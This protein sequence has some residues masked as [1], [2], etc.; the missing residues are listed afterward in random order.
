MNQ[1]GET[2]IRAIEIFKEEN[3]DIKTSWQNA[4]EEII[5]SPSSRK[6][7]CPKCAFLGLC[8]A[9]LVKGVSSGKYL[10]EENSKNKMYAVNAVELL[11]NNPSLANNKTQ[12]WKKSAGD[13]KAHNSQ[14]DVVLALYKAELLNL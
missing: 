14:M 7:V 4:C 9:G 11:A 1:Y 12:L 8:E 10:A 3:K 5:S 2:A 6:K 13:D